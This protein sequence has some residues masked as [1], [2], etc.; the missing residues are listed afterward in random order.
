VI[1]FAG[2]IRSLVS[3]EDSGIEHGLIAMSAPAW[4]HNLVKM[5]IARVKVSWMQAVAHQD[6]P[7]RLARQMRRPWGSARLA[8]Q[9]GGRARVEARLLVE[10]NDTRA[11]KK[12]TSRTRGRD[13]T[14][15]AT[16]FF[17]VEENL[18]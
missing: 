1:L 11:I 15:V 14:E 13:M 4:P 8:S 7:A 10:K 18:S 17:T 16:V 9:T 6:G 12:R 5:A 3:A 2:V